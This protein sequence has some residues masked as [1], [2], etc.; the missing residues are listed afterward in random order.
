MARDNEVP[1][2]VVEFTYNNKSKKIQC[3][4]DWKGILHKIVPGETKK[5]LKWDPNY[6]AEKKKAA[7]DNPFLKV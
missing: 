2:G 3:E 6:L 1:K 5:I 4:Y 7:L